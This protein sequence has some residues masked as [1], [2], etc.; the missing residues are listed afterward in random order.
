MPAVAETP[1]LQLTQYGHFAWRMQDGYFNGTPSAIAQTADGYLWIGTDAGLLRFDGTRFVPWTTAPGSTSTLS[2]VNA[3]VGGQD[4]TLWVGARNG[5]ARLQKGQLTY[6][7]GRMQGRINGIVQAPD[8]TVWLA[9]TRQRDGKGPL[10][11]VSTDGKTLQCFGAEDHLNCSLGQSVSVGRQGDIWIGCS[12]GISRW[13]AGTS[14]YYASNGVKEDNHD[15]ANSAMVALD[16]GGGQMLVGYT[17]KGRNFGLQQ[18]SSGRWQSFNV[19]G[20]IGETAITTRLLLDNQGGLWI[21]TT[22]QG[23]YHVVNGKADHYGTAEGLSGDDVNSIYLDREGS[24]WVATSGGVDRFHRLKVNS[25]S[26]RQGMVSNDAMAVAAR[27]DGGIAVGLVGGLNLLKSN[28]ISSLRS[29]SELPGSMVQRLLVDHIGTLWVAS[30]EQLGRIVGNKFIL[31]KNLGMHQPTDIIEDPQHETLVRAS[32]KIFRVEGQRLVDTNAPPLDFYTHLAP[33]PSDGFWAMSQRGDLLRYRN[34]S[35]Q[36]LSKARP[37]LNLWGFFVGSDGLPWAWGETGLLLWKEHNWLTLDATGG[38][39][40]NAIYSTVDDGEGS[41]W[42]Y[43]RCGIAVVAKSALD[44]WAH[45]ETKTVHPRLLI[46]ATDGPSGAYGDFPAKS[47]RSADGVLWFAWD[48]LLQYVDPKNLPMNLAEPPVHIEQLVADRK[49]IALATDTLL[50]ALTRDIEIDYTA[51]SLVAPQKVR[52]RYKLS[53][54]DGDWREAGSRRQAFYMKLGP[55]H[56]RFQVIACNN[57]GVWNERGDI[58]EFTIPPTFYQT[59]LFRYLMIGLFVSVLWFIYL[60]RVR[61]VAARI[62][63]R[64]SERLAERER[65]AR[66]LHDTILQGFQALIFRIGSA[67]RRFPEGEPARKSMEEALELAREVL[68]EGRDRVKDLRI[69][70]E[71]GSHFVQQMESLCSKLNQGVAAEVRLRIEGFP[72]PMSG[73][74]RDELYQLGKEA[75]VNATLHSQATDIECL[76]T[77]DPRHLCISCRDNGRGIDETTIEAGQVEGHWGLLGMKERAQRLGAT[78]TVNSKKGSGTEVKVRVPAKTAYAP[79]ERRDVFRW[80]A[81]RIRTYATSLIGALRQTR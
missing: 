76:I 78:F 1:D 31:F 12:P 10:C 70:T 61:N 24:V 77:F 59:I 79:N 73:L 56:Y 27:P 8:G 20:F 22:E 43:A 23:L 38:L 52:F 16:M 36:V 55:G 64:L 14:E 40:C 28:D 72:R 41:L 3:L 63:A 74:A 75:L 29:G 25:V 33:D 57:D 30:N 21:G 26:T 15:A 47:A 35:Y 17:S 67:T 39:P 13:A 66:E 81:W 49:P 60:L 7:T 62:E 42:I 2:G 80:L 9:R 46:D 6:V 51:I 34:G 68:I 32:S 19:K 44:A 48:G 54:V 37:E 11:R 65:I 50:P 71:P 58:L 18:L 45:G 53:G 5:F 4:G 69:V